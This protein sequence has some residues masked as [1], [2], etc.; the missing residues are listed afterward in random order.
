MTFWLKGKDINVSADK[1]LL[2]GISKDLLYM[3]GN[4]SVGGSVTSTRG[5][6]PLLEENLNEVKGREHTIRAAV[7][8]RDLSQLNHSLE[9]NA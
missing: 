8:K 7:T 9:K 4:V 1:V 3:E 2:S 5:Y 6:K